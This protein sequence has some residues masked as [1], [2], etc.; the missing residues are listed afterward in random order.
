L[1]LKRKGC[2]EKLSTTPRITCSGCKWQRS[3]LNPG[4]C[5]ELLMTTHRVLD[6][7]SPSLLVSLAQQDAPC[8]VAAWRTLL[9]C[10]EERN[11]WAAHCSCALC[12]QPGLTPTQWDSLQAV[13]RL[14]LLTW[15]T[16]LSVA[17]RMTAPGNPCASSGCIFTTYGKASP[18]SPVPA[19][20]LAFLLSLPTGWL[21]APLG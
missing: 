14:L 21:Y 10:M 18:L 16:H 9:I 2:S 3:D 7:P 17:A 1:W 19:D 4:L 8:T 15:I 11:T 6:H 5:E 13:V 12:P 20:G